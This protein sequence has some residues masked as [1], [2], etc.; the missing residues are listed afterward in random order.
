MAN[1]KKVVKTRILTPYEEKLAQMQQK[2][3][4]G[5]NSDRRGVWTA[6]ETGAGPLAARRWEY[7]N[8][9]YNKA[10]LRSVRQKKRIIQE[11][12]PNEEV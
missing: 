9:M 2:F 4:A 3:E 11:A 10:K 6:E 7:A 5:A 12:T 8:R 1:G